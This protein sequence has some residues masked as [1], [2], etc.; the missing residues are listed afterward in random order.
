CRERSFTRGGAGAGGGSRYGRS[1]LR[2]SSRLGPAARAL[3]AAHERIAHRLIV[4]QSPLF[5]GGCTS[6]IGEGAPVAPTAL[7][8]D[9]MPEPERAL[10]RAIPLPCRPGE[11]LP[12]TLQ[13]NLPPQQRLRGL[14]AATFTP[15]R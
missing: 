14:F 1:L 12:E 3:A 2:L 11:N 5:S 13:M 6:H 7:S 15:L 10:S 4:G 9:V 8:G